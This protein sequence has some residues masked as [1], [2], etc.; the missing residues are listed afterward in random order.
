M[1]QQA[2]CDYYE[3]LQVSPNADQETIER[4]YHFLAKKYHPDKGNGNGN[5]D[6]LRAI[7]EAYRV[8]SDPEKRAAYDAKYQGKRVIE[9]ESFDK[10]SDY[11]DV[12]NDRRIQ[13]GILSLLYWARRRDP[14]NGGV[15]SFEL[16]KSLGAPEKHLEFNIWYL[17]E[18]GWIARSDTGKYVI[19]AT[20]VDAVV[21]N[22]LSIGKDR[23]LPQGPYDT[24]VDKKTNRITPDA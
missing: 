2:L 23:L 13:Q 5:G 21:E 17:K 18:K 15:G 10:D 9:D 4:V 6:K 8:L 3:I 14:L 22:D 11:Y 1:N 7:I 20:G 16:E 24:K 12:K 19:T